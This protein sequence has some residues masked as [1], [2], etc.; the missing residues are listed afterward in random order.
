MG[1]LKKFFFFH[2]KKNNFCGRATFYP[3]TFQQSYFTPLISLPSMPAYFKNAFLPAFPFPYLSPFFISVFHYCAM[4][5]LIDNR[6]T[7]SCITAPGIETCCLSVGPQARNLSLEKAY[8]SSCF[9]GLSSS[10][11]MDIL[12]YSPS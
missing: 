6:Y 12:P 7:S 1:L 10:P 8:C 3:L 9:F 11:N 5:G 4:A 2:L